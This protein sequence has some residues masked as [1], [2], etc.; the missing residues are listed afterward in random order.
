[1]KEFCKFAVIYNLIPDYKYIYYIPS[2]TIAMKKKQFASGGPIFASKEEVPKD[3]INELVVATNLFFRTITLDKWIKMQSNLI[4]EQ[5][6][7]TAIISILVDS[8]A[9][10]VSCH[11]LATLEWWIA[12]RSEEFLGS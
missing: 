10:N 8:F 6:L 5:N 1:M 2:K 12:Q 4:Q 9:H 11:S 7:K 3:T